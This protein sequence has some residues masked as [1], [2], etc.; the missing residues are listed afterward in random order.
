MFKEC[1][2]SMKRKIQLKVLIHIKKLYEI[3]KKCSL[4][5]CKCY[6]NYD[7]KIPLK[8]EQSN[9]DYFESNIMAIA[10]IIDDIEYALLVQQNNSS[11][12]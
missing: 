1:V 10:C 3:Q 4:E 2:N 5:K 7:N 8:I 11:I 9:V 12:S 6:K